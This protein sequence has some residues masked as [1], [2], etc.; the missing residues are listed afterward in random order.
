MAYGWKIKAGTK[1]FDKLIR[2]LWDFG[3]EVFTQSQID[4][5]VD[6]GTLKGSGVLI[7]LPTGFKIVYRTT[8]AAKQEFGVEA[9]TTENIPKHP[10]KR[11]HVKSF[12]RTRPKVVRV[13]AHDRGPHDRGPYVRT[14]KGMIGRFYLTNS[15]E[16]SKPQLV[17]FIARLVARQG[18]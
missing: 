3:E 15:F 8:Y 1:F 16:K 17:K 2:G 9:G 14:S 10:V 4:V 7:K 11:H 13:R 12:I 5:P 6:T 18:Y